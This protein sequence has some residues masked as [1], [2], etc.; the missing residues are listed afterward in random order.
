M[1]T[2]TTDAW[3]APAEEPVEPRLDTTEEWAGPAEEPVGPQL[4][5][6]KSLAVVPH[7][8]HLFQESGTLE[9]VARL[10]ANWFRKHLEAHK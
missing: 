2:D 10:A 4:H 9:E 3:A 8:P 7:A 1:K 5:C 6:A